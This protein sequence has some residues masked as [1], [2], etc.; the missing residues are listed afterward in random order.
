M[1]CKEIKVSVVREAGVEYKIRQASEVVAFWRA[2]VESASWYQEEKESLV[3]ILLNAGNMIIGYNLVTLG[4]LDQSLVHAREVFR[5]ALIAGAGSIILAHNHPSQSQHP[6]A[7]DIQTTK[8]LIEAGKIIG[9][10]LLDHVIMT[11]SGHFS[12][13]AAGMINE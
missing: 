10:K 2:E 12:M 11:K 1:N 13:Q 5:P 4:L 3:V 7:A 8:Q 9:I 6:S